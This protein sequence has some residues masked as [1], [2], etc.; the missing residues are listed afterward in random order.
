MLIT[1]SGV[2]GSGKTTL[3]H[4]LIERLASEGIKSHYL[5]WFSANDSGLG[6]L[7]RA[8]VER[9]EVPKETD[10]HKTNKIKPLRVMYQFFVLSHFLLRTAYWSLLRENVVCDRYLSDIVIFFATELH[11]SE[12]ITKKLMRL[13][14]LITPTPDVAFLVDVPADI[15]MQRKT[16]VASAEQHER[17]RRLYLH[18]AANDATTVLIDGSRD[19]DEVNQMVWAQ[20]RHWCRTITAIRHA[21]PMDNP[22]PHL[23]E[24][25]REKDEG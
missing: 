22:G 11:Y 5:W 20:V 7:V 12:A 13:L 19:L 14:R 2:D 1:F 4:A 10:E 9:A 25:Q 18:L 6:R 15:A 8:V 16:D 21:E 17:L 3:A 24:R 23:S